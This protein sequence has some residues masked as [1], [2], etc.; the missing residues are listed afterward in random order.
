MNSVA[1]YFRFDELGTN[2]RT[3]IIAGLTTFVSMAYI[4]FVNPT[5]LGAAGMDKGAVFTATG[6]AT[7][8]ATIFMGL[9]AR[10]PIAIAPGLGVNAFFAYSVVIGMKVPWQTAMAGVLVA[11]IIFL[12][13]TFFKIRETIINMIPQ[14]LKVAIA[15]GI[16]LFIAFIGLAN[17]GLIVAN[18]STMV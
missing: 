16:G 7:A 8:I 13:L 12:L 9:V 5:V 15:A 6:V 4:L 3:E 14:D 17:A 1:K 18:D 10:Y 2:F 11:A